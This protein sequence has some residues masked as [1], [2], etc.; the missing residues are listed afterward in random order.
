MK[1]KI[2]RCERIYGTVNISGSKNSALPIIAA[3]LLS[4]KVVILKNIPLITDVMI[5]IEI[6]Y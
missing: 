1:L 4:S 3:A 5:L 2:R 6:I